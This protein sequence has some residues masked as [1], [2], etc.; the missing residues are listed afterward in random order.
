[1]E[2]VTIANERQGKPNKICLKYTL[3]HAP[4]EL[5]PMAGTGKH[6]FLFLFLNPCNYINFVLILMVFFFLFMHLTLQPYQPGYTAPPPRPNP[7]ET[8]IDIG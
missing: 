3:Y 8:T 6:C 7:E 1:M 4:P 5:V 2:R